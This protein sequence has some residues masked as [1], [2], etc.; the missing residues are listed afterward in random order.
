MPGS[1]A[2]RQRAIENERF[3]TQR[4]DASL[5]DDRHWVVTA[6]FYAAVHWVDAYL[7]LSNTHPRNHQQRQSL[8]RS[9]PNLHAIHGSYRWLEDRSR[10]ARYDLIVFS[11]QDIQT[12]LS[13][14]FV[15]LRDHL[16]VIVS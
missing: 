15:P 8:I 5:S 2:H 10:E 11:E 16:K 6:L 12:L 4:L 1:V 3:A 7:A 13:R 14:Q 9:D